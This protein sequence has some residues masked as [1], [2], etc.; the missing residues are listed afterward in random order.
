M[1]SAKNSLKQVRIQAE[2]KQEHSESRTKSRIIVGTATCGVSAGA[3]DVVETLHQEVAMR[4][5]EG[6]SVSETG[7]SG[8]CDLEP[9]VQVQM[10]GEAPVLYFHVD[11]EKAKRIIQQHIQLGEVIEDWTVK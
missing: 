6:V 4:H 9:L 5:I 7:C 2:K 11:P 10:D 8:R 1:A 3:R